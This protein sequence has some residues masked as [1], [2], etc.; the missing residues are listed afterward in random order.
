M[1]DDQLGGPAPILGDMN[2][3]TDSEVRAVD[4]V[5]PFGVVAPASENELSSVLSEANRKGVPVTPWGGGT[6]IDL[7]N[8]LARR[9]IVVETGK[10]NRV[11][12]HESADL[13]ATFQAGATVSFVREVLARAGQLLA[14]DPPLPDRA[15]IGGTLAAG[16]AGPMKWHFGHPRD[17]VIGMRVVQPDGRVTKSGGQVVKN[18]SGYDMSRL[19]IGGLGTLGVIVEASFKLTPIPMYEQ[20]LFAPFDTVEK[21][22]EASLAVFNSQVDPLALTTLG[23]SAARLMGIE[24]A[25]RG[26]HVVVRLGGRPRTLD[27][28]VDDVSQLL[29]VDSAASVES[30][31]GA[32]ARQLW[33]SIADFGWSDEL[34]PVLGIRATVGPSLTG[35][36]MSSVQG[37]DASPLKVAVVSQL[38]F[39]TVELNWFHPESRQ[40]DT[41]TLLNLIGRVRNLVAER[42]GV[43]VVQQCPPE[44]KRRIDVWGDS[45]NGMTVMRRLKEQYD[46]NNIMNPGRLSGGI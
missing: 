14:I 28:Q 23:E 8:A 35:W 25:G 31:D 29:N 19:H 22:T 11:V 45:S 5:S 38:G 40:A 27:R 43:A 46:P 13:T 18:V 37:I 21:A 26:N 20:T 17:T 3:G 39:G 2:H 33:R 12:A 6:R 4:G 9:G 42:H 15:T 7:G 10:L 36:L 1:G 44:V 24:L 32:P 41:A 16:L 30:L 34:R